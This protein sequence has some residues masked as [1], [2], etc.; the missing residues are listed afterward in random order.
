MPRSV[1]LLPTPSLTRYAQEMIEQAA[2]ICERPV[3]EKKK[4]ADKLTQEIATI[5][6]ALKERE[7]RQGA[8]VD[9]INEELRVR[10]EV[11][12]KAIEI[13]KELGALISVRSPSCGQDLI[14]RC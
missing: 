12:E 6:K 10:R 9:Q 14:E 5:N 8:S 11:A 1:R 13:C 3:V 4:S 2:S 7:K